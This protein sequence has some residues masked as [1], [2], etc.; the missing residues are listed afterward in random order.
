M[1]QHYFMWLLAPLQFPK[2]LV[3]SKIIPLLFVA[4]PGFQQVFVGS[5]QGCLPFASRPN[6]LST[7]WPIAEPGP[8]SCVSCQPYTLLMFFNF[9]LT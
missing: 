2:V 1:N 8:S 4:H 3:A 9:H 5:G 6:I 7:Q